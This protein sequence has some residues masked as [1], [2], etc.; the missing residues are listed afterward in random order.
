LGLSVAARAQAVGKQDPPDRARRDAQAELTQLAGDPLVAPTRV[1]AREPQHELAHLIVN[2][3]TAK[4]SRWLCPLT[5]NE[6]AVPAQKRLWSD[7]QAVP[8]ARRQ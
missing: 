4:S 8:T 2:R 6:L 7:Q 5:T 3:R 1:L